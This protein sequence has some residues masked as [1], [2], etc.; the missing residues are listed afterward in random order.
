MGNFV[1]LRILLKGGVVHNF[2]VGMVVLIKTIWLFVNVA[3]KRE[4]AIRG[5]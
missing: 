2:I 1:I 3:A 4:H 5:D